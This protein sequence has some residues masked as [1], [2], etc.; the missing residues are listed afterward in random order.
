MFRKH[1][2]QRTH[3]RERARQLGGAIGHGLFE[4]TLEPLELLAHQPEQRHQLHRQRNVEQQDTVPDIVLHQYVVD[5]G[6][7]HED[8]A[9]AED[10]AVL[11]GLTPGSCGD[12]PARDDQEQG[13]QRQRQPQ[14]RKRAGRDVVGKP[15]EIRPG[16]EGRRRPQI[17][18][19]RHSGGDNRHCPDRDR[20]HEHALLGRRELDGQRDHRQPRRG[21]QS[22]REEHHV[23]VA[24]PRD[25]PAGR[26]E[27]RDVERPERGPPADRVVAPA[28]AQELQSRHAQEGTDEHQPRQLQRVVHVRHSA[29]IR[30]RRPSARG[31][32]SGRA[33]LRRGV[34][35]SP[36]GFA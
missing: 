6:R 10:R 15:Q 19:P 11:A 4:A 25:Q 3:A 26:D 31:C 33:R 13:D 2:E 27:H 17:A 29:I 9:H 14:L 34:R 24:R 16:H 32:P 20:W 18:Q 8:Q 28:R 1:V 5:A 21:L 12:V 23:H 35:S 22:Q 7:H 36:G 30:S